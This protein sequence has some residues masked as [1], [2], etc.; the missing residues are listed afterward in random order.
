MARIKY[1]HNSFSV[2]I[3][4]KSVQGNTDF[5]GYNN[6]LDEC[7]NFLIQH[8]GGCFKRCGTIHVSDTIKEKDT[9]GKDIYKESILIP[10]PIDSNDTYII[11]VSDNKFR[12]YTHNGIMM[13]DDNP[14]F[15]E[16]EFSLKD[17]KLFPRYQD[18]NVMAFVTS[19]GIKLLVRNIDGNSFT[20]KSQDFTV[21]P[22][23][24]VEHENIAL[25]P[26]DKNVRIKND[27]TVSGGNPSLG[28]E[29]EF[30][31]IHINKDG[32]VLYDGLNT[33]FEKTNSGDIIAFNYFSSQGRKTVYLKILRKENQDENGIIPQHFLVSIDKTLTATEAYVHLENDIEIVENIYTLPTA[34]AVTNYQFSAKLGVNDKFAQTGALYDGRLFLSYNNVI[35]GSSI[36]NNDHFNFKLGGFDGDAVMHKATL[37]NADRILWMVPQAKL[38][39]GTRSGIYIAGSASYNDAPISPVNFRIRMFDTIGAS[40]LYPVIALD[41]VFFVDSLGIN[42]HEIVLS[43]E[44]GI[45]KAQDLSLLANDLTKSGII[46]HCWQQA[47]TKTYWCAVNDGHLCA[48]TYLKSN[49]VLAWSKHTLG[50]KN[51]RVEDICCINRYGASIVFMVVKREINGSEYRSVEYLSTEYQKTEGEDFRQHYSDCG[52]TYQ[53][54]LVIQNITKSDKSTF[55]I[56][57]KTLKNFNVDV[58]NDRY[59][60]NLYIVIPEISNNHEVNK[61]RYYITNLIDTGDSIIGEIFDCFKDFIT[62]EREEIPRLEH[63]KLDPGKYLSF[64]KNSIAFILDSYLYSISNGKKTDAILKDSAYIKCDRS[65]LKTGDIIIFFDTGLFFSIRRSTGKEAIY[66]LDYDKFQPKSNES[67]PRPLFT[68]DVYNDAVRIF[69]ETNQIVI[70]KHI[71]D[72]DDGYEEIEEFN[73]QNNNAMVL[74]RITGLIEFACGSACEIS[75]SN[76]GFAEDG[77]LSSLKEGDDVF[78]NGVVGTTEINDKKYKVAKVGNVANYDAN[79]PKKTITLYDYSTSPG[80]EATVPLDSSGF[81]LYDTGIKENGNCY[82]YFKDVPIAKHLKDMDV[83]VFSSGTVVKQI[84]DPSNKNKLIAPKICEYKDP[85]DF[86]GIRLI[87][88]SIFV[89]VGLNYKS[90]IKTVPFSGGSVLGSSV[91]CVGNQKTLYSYLLKSSGGNVGTE[92]MRLNEIEYPNKINKRM[93]SIPDLYTGFVKSPLI[94]SRNIYERRIIIEHDTPEPFNVMSITQDISVSDS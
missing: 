73:F 26:Y 16:T 12:F 83:D 33:L 1:T 20:F 63:G 88:P 36:E 69:V 85:N 46:S 42:V 81:S 3:I 9:N 68:V 58:A 18:G 56:A 54:R 64:N 48:L 41:S 86:I 15:L 94:N 76:P 87:T 93:D 6:A 92:E 72:V 77:P 39:V 14:Y 75:V 47:P 70:Y 30:F 21:S 27:M 17:M 44:S 67:F 35:W 49:G 65:Y 31:L 74:K 40:P 7:E 90:K 23:D 52:E 29:Q 78:I 71:S 2:G 22:F 10:F 13:H 51:V 80:S 38:F 4:N 24:P 43:N 79:K 50:G 45:F 61:K 62:P 11:E 28:R 82:I 66:P 5:E 37:M 32:N 60:G 19:K 34:S 8:A 53:K 59:G 25:F 89:S 57:K 55:S 84:V 91:G